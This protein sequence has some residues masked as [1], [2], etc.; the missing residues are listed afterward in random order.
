MG[1]HEHNHG[2]DHGHGHHEERKGFWSTLVN[3]DAAGGFAVIWT[4]IA[5]C[6]ILWLVSH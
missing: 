5:I 6:C 1:H 2:H 3:D 4:I